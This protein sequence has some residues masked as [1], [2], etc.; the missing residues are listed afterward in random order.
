MALPQL[1]PSQ[2]V[3]PQHALEAYDID[4]NGRKW[5]YFASDETLDDTRPTVVM[6]HGFTLGSSLLTYGPLAS[7]LASRYHVIVPDLPGFGKSDELVD[8]DGNPVHDSDAYACALAGFIDAL[9]IPKCHIVAF[10]MGGAITL[11]YVCDS[12]Y[13]VASLLLVSSYGLRMIP[14]PGIFLQLGLQARVAEA[15]VN[16]LLSS[17]RV[18]RVL[19]R[20]V[21]LSGKVD[22]SLFDEVAATE[23]SLPAAFMGWLR[24]EVGWLAHR[25][26]DAPILADLAC[27]VQ[28]VHGTRD[29]VVPVTDSQ[30]AAARY[31]L[32]LRKLKGYGHWLPRQAPDVL[33]QHI[34]TLVKLSLS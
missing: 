28:L 8:A 20:Q 22:A 2:L 1:D 14:F 29:L 24:S 12:L 9:D 16:P 25:H 11:R 32:P 30:R 31:N 33:E 6:L 4:V 13:K 10:S 5:H 23:L 15:L 3:Q 26:H 7:S 18:L 21:V 17:K 19:M 27:P 34:H